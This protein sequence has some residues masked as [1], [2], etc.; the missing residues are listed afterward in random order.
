MTPCR[1][2]GRATERPNEFCDEL[3][4]FRQTS[5]V[6]DK[7]RSWSFQ[8]APTIASLLKAGTWLDGLQGQVQALSGKPMVL[9]D[10]VGAAFGLGMFTCQI[11][12]TVAVDVR[13]IA[14]K[15]EAPVP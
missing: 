13:R 5:D 7:T 15:L 12:F 4:E 10:V 14:T 3:C 2:C 6:A 1:Y 8:P 11:L 9:G